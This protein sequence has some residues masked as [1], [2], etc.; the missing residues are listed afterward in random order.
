MGLRL[1]A[2]AFVTATKVLFTV[3]FIFIIASN[4]LHAWV[5]ELKWRLEHR[6]LRHVRR[7]EEK[8]LG[9]RPPLVTP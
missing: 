3:T 5:V 1:T 4:A 9:N 7:G 2:D 8:E 6:H